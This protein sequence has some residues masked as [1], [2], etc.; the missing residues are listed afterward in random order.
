MKKLIIQYEPVSSGMK[1]QDSEGHMTS[2]GL[3]PAVKA[4]RN[5]FTLIE[6][7][8]VI[9]IIA[10]LAGLLLPALS[11]AKE[12]ARRTQC[13]G[14]LKQLA[15]AWVMYPGDNDDKIMPNPALSGGQGVDTNLQNWVQGYL[16]WTANTPDNTNLSYLLNALCAPYVSGQTAIYRCPDDTWRCDEGGQQM[17]RV[18]SYSMNYCMEGDAEDSAKIA[19]GM[20]L[21]QVYWGGIP[22]YGYRKLTGIGTSFPGP[23]PSDAWVLC[24]EQPD[25]MNNGCL[26]WG[27]EDGGWADMPASYHNQADN[28][29]FAD[30]HVE[31]HQWLSGYRASQNL[32]ICVP[33]TYNTAFPRPGVGNP[34]D[35]R[36]VTDHGCHS[37]P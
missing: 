23:D 13:L 29:S 34:V 19:A 22:R 6:L 28:F 10:I 26:A 18:R 3:T 24:D 5:A 37:Y 9:A 33:V 4:M 31:Y 11:S 30:G 12:K 25:S 1:L 15:L 7:L 35:M 14:N 2:S 16:G 27:S 8:V 17:N 36:W 20:S 21:E 32:G